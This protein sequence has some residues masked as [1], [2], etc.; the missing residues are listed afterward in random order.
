MIEASTRASQFSIRTV[1][2]V[3]LSELNFGQ[4]TRE[5]RDELT[6]QLERIEEKEKEEKEK[7][8][9]GEEKE[10]K[11]KHEFDMTI[12]GSL[13]RFYEKVAVVTVSKCFPLQN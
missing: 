9:E 2:D 10:K 1:K 5:R 8:K 12:V 7:E 4:L 11:R 3:V 6:A 13:I